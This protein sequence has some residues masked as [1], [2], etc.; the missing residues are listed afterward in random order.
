MNKFISFLF[1]CMIFGAIQA[2]PKLNWLKEIQGV[3]FS[4]NEA[5]AVAADT[6]GNV[7]YGG[8]L[9]DSADLDPSTGTNYYR[10][11]GLEDMFLTKLDKNGD[12]LWTFATGSAGTD[13]IVGMTL[14]L[15]GNVYLTGTFSDTLDF[16]PDTGIYHLISNGVFDVF[17]A[18]YL[19]NGQLAWAK[20]IG[21]SGYDIGYGIAR[22]NSGNII[23]TG[24]FEDVTDFDPG[25]NTNNLSAT[26]YE[27]IF[28]LKLD[29]SGNYVWAKQFKGVQGSNYGSGNSLQC[30]ANGNIFITGF[31]NDTFDFNPGTGVNNLISDGSDD[32]FVVKLTSAGA[33]TWA[34]QIGGTDDES[35]QSLVLDASNY[36]YITGY[37][38]DI[39][40][41]NPGTSTFNLTSAGST[42]IF[43]MRL[44]QNGNY[45]WAKRIGNAGDDVS[46]SI[47][48]DATNY[49]YIATSFVGTVDFD[50]GSST[51]NLTA[52]G[53]QDLGLLKLNSSGQYQYAQQFGGS[54]AYVYGGHISVNKSGA[55]FMGGSYNGVVDFDPGS[56]TNNHSSVDRLNAYF[57]RLGECQPTANTITASACKEYTLNSQKY[58]SS[59]TYTQKL[60]NAA[61]C[62][63]NLTL[64]LTILNNGTTI[65]ASVCK[66]YTLNSQTYDKTGVYTQTLTNY[67][68]CDS[69]ITLN[70]IIKNS[71]DTIVASA[72]NIYTLNSQSYTSSGIYYQTL[73]NY[74]NCDSFI[75]LF[76]T[77]GSQ[78][79]SSTV[80]KTT[81][82]SFTMNGQ[83]FKSSGT[84]NQKIKNVSGCDSNITLNLTIKKSSSSSL[85]TT[86][87]RGYVLDGNTYNS[88]GTYTQTLVNKAGCDS[89]LTLN[90]TIFQV[91]KTVTKTGNTLTANATGASYRWLDCITKAAIPGETNQSFNV[92]KDGF[93]QVEVT[94]NTCKDT[95]VC[96]P[97]NGVGVDDL[98]NNGIKVYPNPVQNFIQIE[99]VNEG[100]VVIRVYAFDGA[101]IYGTKGIAKTYLINSTNYAPGIY[102][103]E[104]IQ[105]S[106]VNRV[107]IMKAD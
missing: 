33:L 54:S 31:F 53:N 90:L 100:E 46:Y 34:K 36:S 107:Q 14:D 26:G 32:I 69:V 48:L 17:V 68:N 84:Y 65:N 15:S 49:V 101:Q 50:P 73:K 10:S 85:T 20:N 87:C 29:G 55:I 35:G 19:S 11:K 106:V 41:F 37:F 74:A 88:S 51:N 78:A 77:I 43:V 89:I 6:S 104:M 27:D 47:S 1:V 8:Y 57:M 5:L 2:Q 82:D 91:V 28:V 75:T 94:Q 72:C 22:D 24:F 4:Y 61:G 67:R 95:S 66:D 92:T 96:I 39:V 71:Y 9:M 58:T 80:T 30:D 44:D 102:T 93:Y 23:A 18:K 105:N 64:K 79:T 60:T 56:G 3:T 76:L 38:G 25:S 86:Q 62:D 7:Y 16:D 99:L 103:V 42:D 63:S 83:T 21:G 81:C 12:L 59:G 52:L 98:A 70:L 45:G 40:D 97:M 13:A